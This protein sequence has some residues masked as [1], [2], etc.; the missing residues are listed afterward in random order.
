MPGNSF[1]QLIA[2]ARN[3]AGLSYGQLAERMGGGSKGHLSRIFHGFDKP[4]RDTLIR[5]AIAMNLDV[6]TTDAVLVH[7]GYV[8]LL[9]DQYPAQ[10][11]PTDLDA[12][13]QA[14]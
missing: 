9:D 5:L 1:L 14:N 11:H 10:S 4:K 12:D 7:A 8:G 3:N 2:Q 13:R 6:R